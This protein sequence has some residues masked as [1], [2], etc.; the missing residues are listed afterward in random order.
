LA[1]KAASSGEAMDT[2]TSEQK[3]EQRELRSIELQRNEVFP[4]QRPTRTK[5]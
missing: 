4:S 2:T 1:E 3:L 5:N